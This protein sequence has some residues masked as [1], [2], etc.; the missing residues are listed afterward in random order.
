MYSH[1]MTLMGCEERVCVRGRGG[2]GRA[3]LPASGTYPTPSLLLSGVLP[4]PPSHLRPPPTCARLPP[5]PA[6]SAWNMPAAVPLRPASCGAVTMVSKPPF[7]L[8][9]PCLGHPRP[10]PRPRLRPLTPPPPHTPPHTPPLTCSACSSTCFASRPAQPDICSRRGPRLPAH[11]CM[12][13]CMCVLNTKQNKRNKA[14][15]VH[16]CVCVRVSTSVRCASVC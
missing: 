2:P 12:C 14:A 3:P 8:P 5:A 4:P 6:W 13:M 10:R 11:V 15:I 16:V 1:S 7:P 9:W